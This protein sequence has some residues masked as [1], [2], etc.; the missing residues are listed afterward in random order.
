VL[1][2]TFQTL[3]SPHIIGTTPYKINT[4]FNYA[5]N[6][7]PLSPAWGGTNIPHDDFGNV[8]P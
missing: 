2:T 5:N 4:L 6:Q 1:P 8:V 7:K 3:H